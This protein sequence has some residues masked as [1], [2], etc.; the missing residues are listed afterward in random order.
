[1][2]SQAEIIHDQATGLVAI[3]AVDAR[4]GLH[5]AVALHGLVD[6]H[7]VK[8]RHIETGQPHITHDGNLEGVTRILETIGKLLAAVLVADMA[9]PGK[10]IAGAAGHDNLDGTLLVIIGMPLGAQLDDGIVEFHADA[11]GHADDHGL[12]LDDFQTRVVMF[13]QIPGNQGDAFIRA[14]H[15]FESR[16]FGF[17]LFLLGGFLAFGQFLEL[18]I[19]LGFLRF[20]QFK[21]GQAAFVVDR[22][23]CTICDGLLDIVDADVIAKNGTRV[24]V[25]E[26]QRGGSEADKRGVRQGLVHGAGIPVDKIILAAVGFVGNDDNVATGG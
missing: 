12:A 6:V 17:E 4:N 24:G 9:L 3:D 11:A 5:E 25:L 13:Q 14:D 15:F 2:V 21:F 22:D 23:S 7:G 19:D 20:L 18:G 1:M 10:R 8:R 16:P 26:F